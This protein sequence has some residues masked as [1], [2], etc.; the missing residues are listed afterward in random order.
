[1][2][3][4]HS[5]AKLFNREAQLSEDHPPQPFSIP[6]KLMTA[7]YITVEGTSYAVDALSDRARLLASDLLRTVQ[8]YRALIA[9]YRQSLTLTN[10]YSG[11]LKQEVEKAELPVAINNP[12]SEEDKPTIKIGDVS[13]EANDLPDSVKDYVAE[14]VRANKQKTQLEF[15]LRQLDAAR[16]AYVKAIQ[17]EIAETKP[18]PMDPQPETGENAG[19]ND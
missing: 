3:N 6:P 9:N 2:F 14:L 15:R 1:M 7:P 10:T 19:D 13:Y 12:Y 18:A 16:G 17:D 11:G 8:E 4:L 5:L